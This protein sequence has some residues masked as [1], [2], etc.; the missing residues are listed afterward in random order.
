M[1][2]AA[3]IV[4]RKGDIRF[5][6]PKEFLRQRLVEHIDRFN[7]AGQTAAQVEIINEA[8]CHLTERVYI[9]DNDGVFANIDSATHRLLIPAPW[10]SAGWQYWGLR[11]WEAA[12]LRSLLRHRQQQ[13]PPLYVYSLESNTWHVNIEQYDTLTAASLWL[14]FCPIKIQEWRH[15]SERWRDSAKTAKRRYRDGIE[16]V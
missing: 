10:G 12:V 13:R 7:L 9:K 2:I 14:R 4:E 15:Y 1:T 6:S 5:A 16:T 3:Q 11:Y 8:L